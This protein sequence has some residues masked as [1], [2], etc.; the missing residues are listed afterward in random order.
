LATFF[1]ATT[2]A[3]NPA[4]GGPAAPFRSIQFAV[5]RAV[6]GDTIQVAAG[7]YTYNPATDVTSGNFGT[8]AV[9]AVVNKQLTI[10]G[11]FSTADWNTYNPAANPDY[12][13]GEQPVPG[14]PPRRTGAA[15]G[16]DPRR[17]HGG[18]RARPPRDPRRR[19]A[20]RF[21]GGVYVNMAVANL[22]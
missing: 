7:S 8:T 21:G 12:H 2:G 13:R 22:A 1:V 18:P 14:R 10:R 6:S 20:H 16:A 15:D 11:G 19:P 17:V 3:D 5:N 9:V 4:G